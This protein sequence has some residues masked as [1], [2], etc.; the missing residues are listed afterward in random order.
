MAIDYEIKA[1]KSNQFTD[2]ANVI[3]QSFETVAKEFNIT[4]KNA[5]R[6]VAYSINEY[7]LLELYK[8]GEIM[9]VCCINDEIVGFYSLKTIGEECELNH[10]CVLPAYRRKNLGSGLLNDAENKARSLQLHKIKLSIVYENK[11]LM[12][13]YEKHGFNLTE[14]KKFDF[15]P[16]RCGYMEKQL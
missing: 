15:F 11:T 7:T 10:L 8:H 14:V 3:K 12:Q 13:W 5:P 2:C 6:Y 9:F 16:F 4:A 1:A